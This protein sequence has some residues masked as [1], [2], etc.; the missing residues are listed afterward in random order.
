MNKIIAAAVVSFATFAASAHAATPTKADPVKRCFDQAQDQE[1]QARCYDAAVAVQK[2][3]LNAAYNKLI[4]HR[5]AAN[6]SAGIAALNQMQKD[7]IKS[8]D[9]TVNYLNNHVAGSAS[10]VFAVGNDFMLDA[11]TKQADLLESIR[12]MEGGE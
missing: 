12:D 3:R 9:G 8:R 5:K 10:A 1:Q 7:W 2:K 4:A 6:D 11:V